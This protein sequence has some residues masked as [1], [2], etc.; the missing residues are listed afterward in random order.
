MKFVII[1]A[2]VV[3]GSVGLAMGLF[4]TVGIENEIVDPCGYAL[5]GMLETPRDNENREKIQ[6]FGKI[7]QDNQC[8][9]DPRWPKNG[10]TNMDA[11]FP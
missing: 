10:V 8:W 4:F 5:R 3:I 11:I 6:E 7:L 2:M 1:I 9:N